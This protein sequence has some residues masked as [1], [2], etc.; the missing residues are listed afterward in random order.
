MFKKI[1]TL[2]GKIFL[3]YSIVIFILALVTLW[4]INNFIGLSNSINNI[5]VE[6]YQSIKA[7]ESMIEALE[8]QDSAILMILNGKTNEGKATFREN[9]Q[10]FL[11]WLAR[12]EDNITIDGESEDIESI[13]SIYT[14]YLTLFSEFIEKNNEERRSFYYNEISNEFYEIK[15]EIRDLRSIN[16]NT[17]INAQER[18]DNR[19][20]RAIISTL[21]ISIVAIIVAI[22]FMFYLSKIILEPVKSLKNAVQSIAERNFDQ[23][24]DVKS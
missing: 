12:A 16:Q 4:S 17:M 24:I 19:A 2:K 6:N 7:S 11:K 9:E 23:K 10:E 1:K 21:V 5:M 20:N 22:I 13:N 8:R 15:E 14:E 3:G 18:A